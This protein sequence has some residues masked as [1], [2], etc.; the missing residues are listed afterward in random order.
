MQE[1]ICSL[2]D[3]QILS[4]ERTIVFVKNPEQLEYLCHTFNSKIAV[5]S[6]DST[7]G[8]EAFAE[9]NSPVLVASSD[10]GVGVNLHNVKCTHYLMWS[11]TNW[12]ALCKLCHDQKTGT[13]DSRPEYS[14]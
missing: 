4:N 11:D 6:N 14:Y 3:R 2:I 5:F 9:N 8:Y 10:L 13:E 7:D 1:E 12:Q